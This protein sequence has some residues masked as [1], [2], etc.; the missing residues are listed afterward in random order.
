MNTPIDWEQAM[1]EVQSNAKAA[2]RHSERTLNGVAEIAH[3]HS[4]HLSRL[5]QMQ[6]TL[7]AMQEALK[8][9]PHPIQPSTVAAKASAPFPLFVALGLFVAG[10]M[11]GAFIANF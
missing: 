7:D 4:R 6:K 5:D 9:R 1:T 2:A 11:C 8:S 10:V 3:S